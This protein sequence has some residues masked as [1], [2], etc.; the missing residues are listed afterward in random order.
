MSN[1]TNV[2]IIEHSFLTND[3]NKNSMEYEKTNHCCYFRISFN[4]RLKNTDD[5]R[6][7][8]LR[9][10]NGEKVIF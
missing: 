6:N 3:Y 8:I 1:N 2:S 7:K 4:Y 9:R 10:A 5:F